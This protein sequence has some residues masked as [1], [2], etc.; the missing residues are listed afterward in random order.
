ML[1]RVH[2]ERL[3]GLFYGQ[4]ALCIGALAP[5]NY[6]GT[7]EHTA[8]KTT[9]FKRLVHTANWFEAVMLGSR[10]EADQVL[11]SVHKMH[12]RVHGTLPVQVGPHPAGA[13]YDAFDAE[14][15]LWTVAVMMDSA[16]RFYELLVRRLRKDEREALWQDYVSF[17]VLF[18]MPREAAPETYSAF[19]AYYDGFLS[20]PY[21]WL[22]DAARYTGYA[23]AFEIPMAKHMQ[24]FKRLHDLVML[25]S[26]PPS[27]RRM[28]RL[29]WTPAHAAAFATAV[30]ALRAA[31]LALPRSVARGRNIRVFAGVARTE[32]WRI[33]HGRPTVQLPIDGSTSSMAPMRL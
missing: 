2:E 30:Y 11:A 31:R 9:P 21:A 16:E 10:A 32:A 23:I 22:T 4:R 5:L 24:P 28:Y 14:L 25:G 6:V 7:N 20:S 19:R 13:P 1:R 26:L 33:A 15:M 29:R 18:G 12:T 8:A 17:A 3:V 27:V